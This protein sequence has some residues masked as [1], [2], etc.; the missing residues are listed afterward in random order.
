[1]FHQV[2]LNLTIPLL[3][4]GDCFIDRS[5]AAA[6]AAEEVYGNLSSGRK[7]IMPSP[8]QNWRESVQL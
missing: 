3:P 8:H 6:A 7:G 2:Q 4:S 1:M 5:V